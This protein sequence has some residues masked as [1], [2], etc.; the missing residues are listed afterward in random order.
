M[1]I[2][3]NPIGSYPWYLRP[4]F[5]AQRRRYGEVL[6]PALVWARSP[7]LFATLALFFGALDRNSSPIPPAIRSLVT[8]RVSQINWCRFCVD[9]NGA[10]LLERGM[11]LAKLEAVA[12]WQTS[13]LFDE[14]ER[15]ALEY[16]ERMTDTAL[17][18]D[19]ALMARLKKIFD[20]DAIVELTGLIA[21][22][23]LS[24]KFNAA[25]DVPPQGFCKV[26]ESKTLPKMA[27]G[28]SS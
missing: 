10:T 22:Q 14:R 20:D 13:S 25:L 3:P 21:F 8:V 4:F 9:I 5:W 27:S 24:S 26:P 2:S 17:Q 15:V 28:T 1:R 23:N 11:P 6:E 19:D 16:A 18:V 12:E 7:K